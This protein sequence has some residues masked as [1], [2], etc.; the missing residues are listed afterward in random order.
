M[1]TNSRWI[2]NHYAK[3]SVLVSCGKCPACLQAKANKRA[4]RI[5]NE[6]GSSS[7]C[8]FITLTYTNDFVP[9]VKRSDLSENYT[10]EIDVY[11]NC[12]GR[13]VFDR[14][15]G[16]VSFKKV[17]EIECL[18]RYNLSLDS[19]SDFNVKRYPHL[20]G[21]SSEFIGVSLFSEY[22][23]FF[24]RLRII[25]QRN[26]DFT[27]H[28]SYFIC[29]EFGPE[30]FRPHAHAL[31]FVPAN[32]E[33]IFRRA[34]LTAWPYADSRLTKKYIEIARDAA[35]YVSAY[36][37]SNADLFPIMQEDVFKPK[38]SSSKNFGV[39]SECFSLGSILEK[40]DRRDLSYYTRQKFDGETTLNALPI[41]EYV[42]SRYFP[43]C[44]GFGWLSSHELLRLLLAPERIGFEFRDAQVNFVHIDKYTNEKFPI[45]FNSVPRIASPLYHFSCKETY[46]FYVR[47]FNCFKHFNR[48]TGLGAWDYV[49]YYERCWSLRF[50]QSLKN[51]FSDIKHLSDF[52]DF[53]SNGSDVED[54]RLRGV[55]ICPTLKDIHLLEDFNSRSDVVA[56]TYNLLRLFELKDKS[57]KVSNFVMSRNGHNV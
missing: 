15:S 29:T 17:R 51:S 52:Q 30:T 8:L 46:R 28:F 4:E 55:D 42:L 27:Q 49:Y 57:K 11:R 5:R 14:H 21:L 2:Y 9:Y 48:V 53:Y 39:V 25:L 3:R 56:I 40:I 24:K 54:L 12:S 34:I 31:L 47:L 18:G 37:N 1:C 7:I 19:V 41:P 50:S 10:G 20:K 6:V 44:K 26:Y 23:K 38:H 45:S 22:Q 16:K 13:F 33:E 35:S 36:V 32:D 43:K